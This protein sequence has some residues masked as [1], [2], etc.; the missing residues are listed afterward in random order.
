[1]V[2]LAQQVVNGGYAALMIQFAHEIKRG[3]KDQ[4]G[5]KAEQRR[6]TSQQSTPAQPAVEGK[7]SSS[8][9]VVR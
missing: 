2:W 3:S 1:M 4:S 6:P 7:C 8:A 9:T 5:E